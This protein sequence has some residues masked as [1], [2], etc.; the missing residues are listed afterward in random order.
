M[1]I[2]TTTETLWTTETAQTWY[3][4]ATSVVSFYGSL[5]Y[6]LTTILQPLTYRSRRKLQ[7]TENFIDAIKTVLIP[8]DYKVVSFVVAEIVM[9]RIHERAF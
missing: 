3:I 6:H 2:T 7:S 5:T 4:D 9:Q 8:D 1:L